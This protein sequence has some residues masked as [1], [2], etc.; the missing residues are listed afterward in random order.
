MFKHHPITKEEEKPPKVKVVV[1][2]HY[3]FWT[4]NGLLHI[5]KTKHP[6]FVVV[7]SK[8]ELQF[9]RY[10]FMQINV[11]F[12]YLALHGKSSMLILRLYRLVV[13]VCGAGGGGG[14]VLWG[15]TAAGSICAGLCLS[16]PAG[17]LRLVS[18]VHVCCYEA[19]HSFLCV[20]HTKD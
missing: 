12:I 2:S 8:K 20:F 18:H 13:C 9:L 14:G 1:L 17:P 11:G 4:T 16:S 10:I 6:F 7:G 19:S 5:A 15:V 3:L